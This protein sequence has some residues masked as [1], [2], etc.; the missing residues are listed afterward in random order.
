MTQRRLA[1]KS[2]APRES[3][4]LLRARSGQR[5]RALSEED[6]C[7]DLHGDQRC[8]QRRL[9]DHSARQGAFYLYSLYEGH[10]CNPWMYVNG[11]V[12]E[13]QVAPVIDYFLKSKN[14]KNFFLV[15]N[16]YAFGRS[17]LEFSRQ[18][19]QQHCGK[20]VGEEYLP[21]DASDWTLTPWVWCSH[22]VAFP[23]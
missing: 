15:G 9:A 13:Q 12:P 11:P 19:I 4:R 2:D 5:Y 7:G 17:M 1:S 18:Y 6:R 10:S 20:V 21:I 16:D 8:T 22:T 14:A 3:T 23:S